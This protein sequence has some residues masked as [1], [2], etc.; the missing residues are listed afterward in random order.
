MQMLKK[1]LVAMAFFIFLLLV[2]P[3]QAETSDDF[4]ELDLFFYGDLDNGN[5]NV[6]T[7]APV[8]DT[9]TQSDCPQEAN[10]LSWPGQD[11]QWTS[12]GSWIV[13]LETPGSIASGEH[14]LSLIHIS[15]P[16]RRM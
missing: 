2:Q 6:S 3:G 1:S 9:D 4:N 12:V 13:D 14:M 7:M 15:E 8:S 10:R 5:G 11:R 16:T